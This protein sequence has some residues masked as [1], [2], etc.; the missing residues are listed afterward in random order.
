MKAIELAKQL[1]KALAESE[2]YQSY[3][4][5]KE[6]LDSH[7]AAKLMLAD[8]R[9][10]QWDLEK[11]R[12][13]GELNAEAATTELQKLAEVIQINPY[14]REYLFAEFR[15]SQTML[16]VQRIIGAAVGIDDYPEAP[17]AEPDPEGQTPPE[18]PAEKP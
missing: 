8:F 7:E 15:F 18:S 2:E 13:T 9:K 3:H 12:V 16:E 5:A 1:G 14:I 17:E 10:K 4:K 6:T 11:R